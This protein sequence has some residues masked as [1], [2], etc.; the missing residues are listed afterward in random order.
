[1]RVGQISVA[2]AGAAVSVVVHHFN[3]PVPA[4]VLDRFIALHYTD[5]ESLNGRNI[6]NPPAR[7][8]TRGN[9]TST[10]TETHCDLDISRHLRLYQLIRKLHVLEMFPCFGFILKTG[11]KQANLKNEKSDTKALDKSEVSKR[12]LIISHCALAAPASRHVSRND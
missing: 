11:K 3:V 10:K 4:D 2:G 9:D 1:M 8:C 5:W 7:H 6:N 12:N